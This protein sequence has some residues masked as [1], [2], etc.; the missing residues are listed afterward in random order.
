MKS[1]FLFSCMENILILSGSIS[2]NPPPPLSFPAHCH[3]PQQ[4]AAP[5]VSGNVQGDRG[6]RGNLP[7]SHE[8][9]VQP[10]TAHTQEVWPKG[11][12]CVTQ[13]GEA[14]EGK[15][16]YS[17]QF[18]SALMLIDWSKAKRDLRFSKESVKEFWHW[19]S[20]TMWVFILLCFFF[21]FCLQGSLVSREASFKEKVSSNAQT[22]ISL[23]IPQFYV[24]SFFVFFPPIQC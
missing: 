12:A 15:R 9:R 21:F 8:E 13:A 24:L 11:K 17:I 3:L 22:L 18:S 2:F 14:A 20:V 6:E 4:H 1:I 16:P 7:V 23:Y 10:Q 19:V 5:S